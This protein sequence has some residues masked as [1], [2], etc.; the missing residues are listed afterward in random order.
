[1]EVTVGRFQTPSLTTSINETICSSDPPLIPNRRTSLDSASIEA[2]AKDK[3]TGDNSINTLS[4]SFS[5]DRFSDDTVACAK[6]PPS[7]PFK[8]ASVDSGFRDSMATTLSALTMDASFASEIGKMK[9]SFVT[10]DEDSFCLDLEDSFLTTG[11]K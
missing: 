2:F 7:K 6:A 11:D 8:R 1:M 4:E 3:N 9:E 5:F 10:V